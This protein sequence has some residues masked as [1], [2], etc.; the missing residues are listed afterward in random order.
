[1]TN[2]KNFA[3]CAISTVFEILQNRVKVLE[4]D[5]G[6]STQEKIKDLNMPISAYQMGIFGFEREANTDAT[7]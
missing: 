4:T 2:E 5:I 6:V 1:M 3:G 7:V